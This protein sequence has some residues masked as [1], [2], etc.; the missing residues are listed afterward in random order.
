MSLY[1]RGIIKEDLVNT[2]KGIHATIFF[3]GCSHHCKECF[4]PETWEFSNDEEFLLTNEK[5][6]EF[7]YWCNQPYIDGVTLSGGDPMDQDTESMLEFL[8]RLKVQ[9]KK[10]IYC[11]T[12][13]TFEKLLLSDKRE[14]LNYIDVLVDGEFDNTKKKEIPLRG[15][16]NQRVIDVQKS[17]NGNSTVL[18]ID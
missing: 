17:L 13:Y 9:V 6:S 10:P 8:L 5:Q 18:L 3:Q 1:Y 2:F 7:V 12:G 11:W 4:N 15:S 14:L 16:T